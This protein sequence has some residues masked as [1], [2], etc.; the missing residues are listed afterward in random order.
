MNQQQ[1]IAIITYANQIDPLIPLNESTADVWHEALQH[2]DYQQALWCVKDYYANTQPGRDG[3]IPPLTSAT[4][5]RRIDQHQEVHDA[6]QRA[7][8]ARPT[9]HPRQT[10]RARNPEKWDQ[11]V[12]QG[13]QEF[14]ENV[15]RLTSETTRGV[16]PF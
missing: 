8:S 6:K 1:T 13:Q 4:L 14:R 15:Q 3:R 9:K 5:R 12:K 16:A 10:F 7:I 11:L 2:R